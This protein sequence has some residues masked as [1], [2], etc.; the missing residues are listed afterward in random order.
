MGEAVDK[1]RQFTADYIFASV[2]FEGVD[3]FLIGFIRYLDI[4]GNKH[5]TG[6]CARFDKDANRFALQGGE[7]YNYTRDK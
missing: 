1:K 4:F 6:Y 5:I 3:I 2:G 7:Q